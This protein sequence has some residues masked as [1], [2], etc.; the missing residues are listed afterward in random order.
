MDKNR[1]YSEMDKENVDFTGQS[2][3][4]DRN[5]RN[6]N[7]DDYDYDYDDSDYE[8]LEDKWYEIE[9]D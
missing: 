2:T 6:S 9:D 1:E 8:D 4:D 5:K 3:Y 7:N